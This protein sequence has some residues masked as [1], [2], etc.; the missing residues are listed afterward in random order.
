LKKGSIELGLPWRFLT[1][2]TKDSALGGKCMLEMVRKICGN[3]CYGLD[4]FPPR[5][6]LTAARN[7]EVGLDRTFSF[8]CRY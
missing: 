7:D 6:R 4:Y 8:G 1:S 3:A 5:S 2:Q